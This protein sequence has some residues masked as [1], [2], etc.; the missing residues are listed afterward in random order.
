MVTGGV[1]VFAY[2]VSQERKGICA[3]FSFRLDACEDDGVS[4]SL[5]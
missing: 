2:G 5:V 4:Y 3:D 1:S